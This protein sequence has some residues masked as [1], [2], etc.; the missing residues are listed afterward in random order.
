MV[1]TSLML[2]GRWSFLLVTFAYLL[3]LN[4]YRQDA[5]V[6]LHTFFNTKYYKLHNFD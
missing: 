3:I 4:V 1:A 6:S 2:G 5:E